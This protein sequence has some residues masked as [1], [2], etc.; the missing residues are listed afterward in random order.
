[1]SNGLRGKQTTKPIDWRTAI[2][3]A[4]VRSTVFLSI[5]I[6]LDGMYWTRLFLWDVMQSRPMSSPKRCTDCRG[7]QD[8]RSGRDKTKGLSSRIRG[9]FPS[10]LSYPRFI[11]NLSSGL[12]V[13][14]K[15]HG[16][17]RAFSTQRSLSVHTHLH[18]PCRCLP[19]RGYC[20]VSHLLGDSQCTC[21]F[22]VSPGSCVVAFRCG[23]PPLPPVSRADTLF[24]I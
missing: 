11:V 3:V 2:L 7:G 15:L 9:E 1:M 13:S 6:L 21:L 20:C 18:L 19:L 5:S 24:L 14:V 23:P 8:V 17:F 10:P 22:C 12:F 16:R 4:S